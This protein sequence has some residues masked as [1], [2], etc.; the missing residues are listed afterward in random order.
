MC[1]SVDD[2]TISLRES[3]EDLSTSRAGLAEME[4][5]AGISGVF[6]VPDCP[7]HLWRN[8]PPDLTC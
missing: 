3:T 2:A 1:G 4:R 5:K 6:Q 8:C 7:L